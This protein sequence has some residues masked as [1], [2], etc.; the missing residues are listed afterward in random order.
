[1]IGA[2]SGWC[3]TRPEPSIGAENVG[4]RR[5]TR[6]DLFLE[7]LV[8]D[9]GRPKSGTATSRAGGFLTD[10]DEA[11]GPQTATS[12]TVRQAKKGGKGLKLTRLGLHRS[13]PSA[14]L[15]GHARLGASIHSAEKGRFPGYSRTFLG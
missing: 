7:C 12:V 11:A 15:I 4:K 8:R 9:H 10:A 3:A 2:V 6:E 1:V 5:A 13:R 14:P